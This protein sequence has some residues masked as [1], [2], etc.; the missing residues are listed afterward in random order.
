MK[1]KVIVLILA[2]ALVMTACGRADDTVVKNESD[3]N[4][5]SNNEL[6][7]DEEN[8]I[9][10]EEDMIEEL[11]FIDSATIE[12]TIMV[13]QE[14]VVITATS[15]TYTDYD[16][17]LNISIENTG[18]IDIDVYTNTAGYS[19]NSVNGYMIN[20]GYI[21]ST[22]T[23]GKKANET[24]CFSKSELLVCGITEIADIEIGF[25][26]AYAETYDDI[27]LDPVRIETTD[28]ESYDYSENYY[29]DIIKSGYLEDVYDVCIDEYNEDVIYEQ[30]EVRIISTVQ[31]TNKDGEETIF[32]E[33]VN[34][35]E[36][37]VY[38][39]SNTLSV[40]GILAYNA[41]VSCDSINPGAHR[42]V[43]IAISN[44]LGVETR[45]VL[46]ISEIQK[47]SLN[48][49]L[50]NKEYD[51]L[52][53]GLEVF[54]VPFKEMIEVDSSGIEVYANN[55]IR[56]IYKGYVDEL[57]NDYGD[58]DLLFLIENNLD[59][60]ISVTDVT[61]TF[62]IDGYMQDAYIFEILV[63]A[64]QYAIMKAS[65]DGDDLEEY[66][67]QSASDISEVEFS[68]EIKDEEYDVIDEGAIIIDII[69]G[70]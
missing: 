24:I 46:G 23:P 59:E 37:L 21:H 64:N 54:I 3:I 25:G 19:A 33:I 44:Y 29:Q 36:E 63:R 62:S 9:S 35:S 4:V 15:L 38:F 47:V 40:N 14:N 22:V 34:D 8:I 6:V 11:V 60:N 13:E 17:E 43:D 32:L 67:I 57:D 26:I 56:V 31:M 61:D 39:V 69:N 12:E 70:N 49:E 50:R 68:I 53:D 30:N 27:D 55:D 45:S 42:I 28:Y 51:A 65:I 48:C 52:G 66:G 10:V 16:V 1:S 18:E 41:S 7:S 20:D 58:L 5:E 2:L